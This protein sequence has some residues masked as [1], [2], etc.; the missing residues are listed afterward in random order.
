MAE[1]VD[2]DACSGG[3]DDGVNSCRGGGGGGS[4]SEHSTDWWT[5][6]QT[7]VKD[8]GCGLSGKSRNSNMDEFSMSL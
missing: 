1:S 2:I 7:N 3:E 4:V 5:R 8:V 6:D